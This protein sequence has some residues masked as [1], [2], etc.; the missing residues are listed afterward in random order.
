MV[1]PCWGRGAPARSAGAGADPG[2]VV[3]SGPLERALERGQVRSECATGVPSTPGGRWSRNCTRSK[4]QGEVAYAFSSV[5]KAIHFTLISRAHE[6]LSYAFRAALSFAE[7]AR[8][9]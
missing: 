8:W 2:S 3:S 9:F 6:G 4:R 5:P 1:S 7:R